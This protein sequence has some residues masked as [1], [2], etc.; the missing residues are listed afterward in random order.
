MLPNRPRG[1]RLAA[2]LAFTIGGAAA[3]AGIGAGNAGASPRVTPSLRLGHGV[4]LPYLHAHSGTQSGASAAATQAE[5][6]Y[7]GGTADGAAGK[8]GVQVHQKVY[9]IFWGSQWGPASTSGKDLTFTNDPFNAAPYVQDFL[10]GLYGNRD[11]WSTSTTQYCQG[12][13]ATGATKCS[14]KATHVTHPAATPLA[15]VWADQ[16]SLA[17]PDATRRNSARRPIAPRCTSATRHRGRTSRC[18]T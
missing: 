12:K 17:P 18:S 14:T 15:G 6:K 9:L 10:R 1:A 11:T 4:A 16:A 2:A 8:I 5:L 13:V 7:Y 3:I